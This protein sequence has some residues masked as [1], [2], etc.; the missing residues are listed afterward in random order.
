MTRFK[1]E[2]E[3]AVKDG[4][5]NHF[6][7]VLKLLADNNIP[8]RSG[9]TVLSQKVEEV[10]NEEIPWTHRPSKWVGDER[11]K[12][13]L[14]K[15]AEMCDGPN[16]EY[17]MSSRGAPMESEGREPWVYCIL[18]ADRRDTPDDGTHE[19]FKIGAGR[20]RI[21]SELVL[22]VEGPWLD[23]ADWYWIPMVEQCKG[24]RI[25]TEDWV[26]RTVHKDDPEAVRRGAGGHGGAEFR[27][28]I[29]PSDLTKFT[30]QG[31]QATKGPENSGKDMIITH[32]CWYQGVIPPKHRHLFK[33]NAEMVTGFDPTR[34]D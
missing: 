20:T 31:I 8:A 17:R 10:E 15:V 29:D 23:S 27:F 28:L 34:M 1:H 7:G 11:W 9:W 25:V 16:A 21:N 19:V 2:I 32:N 26:H 22:E 12:L 6:G 4:D 24:R 3:V 5:P 18:K 30:S 33:V 14:D 13:I